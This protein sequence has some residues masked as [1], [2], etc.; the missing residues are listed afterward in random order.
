M[1][2]GPCIIFLVVGG[3]TAMD[4]KPKKSFLEKVARS[5]FMSIILFLCWAFI[6]GQLI[7]EFPEQRWGRISIPLLFGFVWGVSGADKKDDD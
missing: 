3:G 6:T 5:I 4:Q 2:N 1:Y 7:P